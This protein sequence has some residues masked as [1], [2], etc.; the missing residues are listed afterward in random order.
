MSDSRRTE[1][2]WTAAEDDILRSMRQ[3][4][5]TQKEI[6]DAVGRSPASVQGRIRT[7]RV[8]KG[9]NAERKPRICDQRCGSCRYASTAGGTLICDYLAIVGRRRECPVGADCTRYI[10]GGRIRKK[11]C[12][13]ALAE[14]GL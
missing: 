6:A 13:E 5:A 3:K 7:L 11:T 8:G 14:W 9:P 12:K 2:R 1:I 4:G 10:R